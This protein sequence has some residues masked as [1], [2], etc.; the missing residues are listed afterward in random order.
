[1]S[2]P[3]AASAANSTNGTAANDRRIMLPRYLE[4]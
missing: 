2:Q 3:A 1:L 4:P